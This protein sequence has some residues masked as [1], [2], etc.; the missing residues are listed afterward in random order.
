MGSGGERVTLVFFVV[1]VVCGARQRCY[2]RDVSEFRRG[3][4]GGNAH[5]CVCVDMLPGGVAI[6]SSS[7]YYF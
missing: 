3:R 6:A 4:G 1:V 7:Y 2:V 5:V